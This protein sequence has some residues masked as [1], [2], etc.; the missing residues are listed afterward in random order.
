VPRLAISILLGGGFAAG[1]I[2]V[3]CTGSDLEI[4]EADG[5]VPRKDGAPVDPAEGGPPSDAAASLPASC[6]K[7]CTLVTANCTGDQAQYASLEDC[8]AF[9]RHLPLEGPSRDGDQKDTPTTA[10][11]QYWADSPARTDPKAHCSAAGPF[12]GNTCGDRCTAF[13]DVALDACGTA[14]YATPPD[15]TTACAGF[16]FRD[17]GVDGG[18]EG[19]DGPAR[20]ATL[21]CRLY[22]LRAAAKDAAA[23]AALTPAGPCQN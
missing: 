18:G 7:Y 11:R 20:G 16:T 5:A 9:C 19:P 10:C 8:L 6:A 1:V 17:A 21:N 22:H 4:A 3:A 15:C 13:C 12:G 14:V 2:A 23:C